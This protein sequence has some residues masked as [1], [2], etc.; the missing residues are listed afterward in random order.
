MGTDGT[1]RALEEVD[2]ALHD[3]LPLGAILRGQ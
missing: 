3:R 2:V 1:V